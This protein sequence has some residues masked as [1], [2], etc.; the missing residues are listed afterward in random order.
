MEELII[1]VI[2]LFLFSMVEVRTWFLQRL[3]S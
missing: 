3:T 1:R 2:Y